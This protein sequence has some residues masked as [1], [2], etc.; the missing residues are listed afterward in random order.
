MGDGE[1]EEVSI[2]HIDYEILA[3]QKEDVDTGSHSHAGHMLCQS[4]T[5]RML[6]TAHETAIKFRPRLLLPWFI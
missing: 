1:V 2:R 3:S 6:K 4:A 5:H